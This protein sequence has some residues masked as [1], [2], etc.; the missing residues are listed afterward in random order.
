MVSLIARDLADSSLVALKILLGLGL[1]SYS[2]LRQAGMDEREAQ[3][4]VNDFGRAP[5]GISKEEIV[6]LS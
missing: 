2:A 1:L 5:V 4:A 3:D 6:S